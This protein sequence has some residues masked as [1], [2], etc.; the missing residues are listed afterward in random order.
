MTVTERFGIF[1]GLSMLKTHNLLNVLDLIIVHDLLVSSIADIQ[2]LTL[3][4]EDTVVIT[5][6]NT[7]TT[8]GKSLGGITLSEDEGTLGGIS[9]TG[10]VGVV[11]LDNAIDTPLLLTI[12]LFELSI[13]LE[14]CP[15]EDVI[16]DTT[17]DDGLHSLLAQFTGRTEFLYLRVHAFFRLR[18][19]GRVLN[20]TIDENAHLV[21]DVHGLHRDAL[22]LLLDGCN[23]LI[24]NLID[25][26]VDVFTTLGGGNGVDEGN[27]LVGAVADGNAN[28]PPIIYFLVNERLL[29]ILSE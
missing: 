19:E 17:V 24:N 27:L 6:N 12:I 13:R 26:I 2:Q 16:S 23:E 7:E 1:I 28:L 3:E 20:E 15:V 4:W 14:L 29:L 9:A 10:I 8:H 21:L 5:A 18:V 25:N 11:K 22:V